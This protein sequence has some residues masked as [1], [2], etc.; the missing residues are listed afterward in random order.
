MHTKCTQTVRRATAIAGRRG[1]VGRIDK[2]AAREASWPLP[3]PKVSGQQA[4][5]F[6]VGFVGLFEALLPTAPTGCG[7][8]APAPGR[9]RRPLILYK[10]EQ[11]NG[12]HH[13]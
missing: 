13:G 2:G 11:R 7:R 10:R 3:H 6:A 12:G 9:D 1:G 8:V 4:Q 5:P